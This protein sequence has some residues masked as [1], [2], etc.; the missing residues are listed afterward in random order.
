MSHDPP[1][2]LMQPDCEEIPVESRAAKP[3]L[4]DKFNI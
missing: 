1:A 4:L 2:L 3:S